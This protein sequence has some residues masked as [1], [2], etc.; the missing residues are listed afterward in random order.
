MRTARLRPGKAIA[1]DLRALFARPRLAVPLVV[2]GAAILASLEAFVPN[3]WRTPGWADLP[4]LASGTDE[5]GHHWI[6]AAD[7]ALT[8]VEFSDYECPHCRAA[9]KQIRV[10]AAKH[11]NRIRLVHRHLPL[12]MACNQRLKR[13]FHERA[14]E[15][16]EVAECAG[17]QGRFWEMNDALF[18]VQETVKTEDVDPVELAVRLGLNRSELRDCL[19]RHETAGRVAADL[20]AAFLKKLRGTPSF[21][22]GERLFV[23]RIPEVEIERLLQGAR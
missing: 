6:G 15:F 14:C 12:D 7:P 20:R 16:A 13:P 5:G 22:V 4:S 23:G 3:Y 2:A 17:L 8:I 9:H 10:L 19:E 18:S 1:G 21:L 11:A